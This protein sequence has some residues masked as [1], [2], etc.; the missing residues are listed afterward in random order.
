LIFF[1]TKIRVLFD[2]LSYQN[3]KG[4]HKTRNDLEQFDIHE[5]SLDIFDC[6]VD[7]G[8]GFWFCC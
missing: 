3:A 1:L 7:L 5:S 2:F 8:D 6:M 4:M